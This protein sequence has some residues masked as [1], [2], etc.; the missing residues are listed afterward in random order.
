MGSNQMYRP[1]KVNFFVQFV[2]E[3][4]TYFRFH[5]LAR[6][7]TE[8]GHFVQIFGCDNQ[9]LGPRRKE[10]RDGVTYHII[11]SFRGQ[12]IIHPFN[13]PLNALAQIPAA[14]QRCDVAHLFQPFATAALGWKLSKAKIRFFDWDDL[15][16]G[17]LI[18][19]KPCHLSERYFNCVTSRLEANLPRMADATTVCSTYLKRLALARGAKRVTVLGNGVFP[20]ELREQGAARSQLGLQPK[21]TYLGF[22]G[23][24]TRELLWCFEL[25][26]KGR[27]ILPN[28]RLAICGPARDVLDD[29][30]SE[31]R[32]AVDHLG[33]L[34]ASDVVNFGSAIDLG[35]IPLQNDSFNQSRFPIKFAEH[36]NFGAPIVCSRVGECGRI[37]RSMPWVY[38]ASS[39]GK[40]AWIH[41][42]I[43]A[44]HALSDKSAAVVDRVEVQRLLSWASL[45]CLLEKCYLDAIDSKVAISSKLENATGN[46]FQ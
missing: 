22:M 9:R 3:Q 20:A 25:L 5:N 33:S 32:D 14:G 44:I 8:R 42:G 37:G 23:R 4:G 16:C 31:L 45:S 38:L 28:L 39:H 10:L 7:L 15:W 43:Q 29:L 36:M 46:L 34:P 27:C 21:A 12:S 1:L 41:A 6:A 2:H 30:P 35:L 11:P 26:E 18:N 40:E 13:H 24:T 17:G 19:S